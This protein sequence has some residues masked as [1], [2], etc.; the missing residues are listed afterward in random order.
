MDSTLVI[1]FLGI[2]GF[3]GPVFFNPTFFEPGFLGPGFFGPG[4]LGP[5]FFEPVFFKPGLWAPLLPLPP[6]LLFFPPLF[7]FAAI[8]TPLGS[9]SGEENGAS[10]I[11][12]QVNLWKLSKEEPTLPLCKMDLPVIPMSF[13]LSLDDT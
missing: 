8:L 4:F 6:T 1:A 10:P 9:R 2:L 11:G 5:V 12:D 7:F 13:H 3:P